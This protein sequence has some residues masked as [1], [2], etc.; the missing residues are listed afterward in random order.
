MPFD[1]RVDDAT[2]TIVVTGHGV[3]SMEDTLGAVRGLTAALE[4]NPDYAWMVDARELDYAPPVSDVTAIAQ[5]LF[6]DRTLFSNRFLLLV[7]PGI[8][9]QLARIFVALAHYIGIVADVFTDEVEA[10]LWLDRGTRDR[11]NQVR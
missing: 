2:H 9:E 8:Q 4:E 1:F 11:Y 3:G 5:S 6:R 7:K 10:L